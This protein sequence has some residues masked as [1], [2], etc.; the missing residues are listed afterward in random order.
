LRHALADEVAE[1]RLQAAIALGDEGR[2]T[3]L[4][5]ALHG[6]RQSGSSVPADGSGLEDATVA[7]A[8]DALGEHLPGWWMRLV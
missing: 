6:G 7:R 5:I 8:I 1:V 3:L 4:E 2:Q